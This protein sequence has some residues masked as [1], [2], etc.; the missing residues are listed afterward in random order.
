MQTIIIPTDFS[1]TSLHAARFGASLSHYL[2]VQR[3]VLY[4]SAAVPLTATE[5]PLA[6]N[7]YSERQEHDSHR[8]LEYLRSILQPS[9]APRI[10]IEI[11]SDMLP[12]HEALDSLINKSGECLI[13]MGTSEQSKL[14]QVILGS[15]TISIINTSRA[16]VLIVPPQAGF[17]KIRNVVLAT[18]LKNDYKTIPAENIRSFIHWLKAKLFILNVAHNERDDFIPDMIPEIREMHEVW[19]KDN[20]EYHYTIHKDIAEGIRQF[21]NEYDAQL[22]ILV[23]QKENFLEKLFSGGI[24]GKLARHTNVPLLIMHARQV[25]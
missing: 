20:P 23:H 25:S 15:D 8:Q 6:G 5:V 4:H 18:D 24:S 3:I 21:A 7:Y 13:I 16:P 14:E 12:L 11:V 9:V 19:E 17:E 22:I 1:E 10:F 2:P